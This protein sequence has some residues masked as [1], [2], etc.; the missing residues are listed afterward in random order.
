MTAE[1]KAVETANESAVVEAPAVETAVT[2]A[3]GTVAS[4]G[5]APGRK[6]SAEELIRSFEEGQ[7]KSDLPEIYVGDTVRVGVRIR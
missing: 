5:K 6:L 3:P 1:E 4:K 7:L 2:E